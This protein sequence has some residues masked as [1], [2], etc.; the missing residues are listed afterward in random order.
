MS[1]QS[2]SVLWS[3]FPLS[4]MYF[5]KRIETKYGSYNVQDL[6]YL[7]CKRST[8]KKDFKYHF[9]PQYAYEYEQCE[10]ERLENWIECIVCLINIRDQQHT[11]TYT[12]PQPT[13]HILPQ[14]IPF[15]NTVVSTSPNFDFKN[16]SWGS[17]SFKRTLAQLRAHN[18]SLQQ[19]TKPRLKL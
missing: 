15:Q 7:L 14:P 10:I 2:S 18:W 3:I 12:H 11:Q 16:Q 6:C 8:W 19:I 9:H 5:Y 17:W 13:N 4:T 1:R